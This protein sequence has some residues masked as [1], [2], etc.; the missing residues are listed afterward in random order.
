ME[1]Y[2]VYSSKS[3]HNL[4]KTKCTIFSLITNKLNTFFHV[5]PETTWATILMLHVLFSL[6][7]TEMSQHL[8]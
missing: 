5:I 2:A 3:Y 6:K 4:E 8:N 7:E 1:I